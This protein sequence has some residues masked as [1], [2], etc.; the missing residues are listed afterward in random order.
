MTKVSCI[1][2]IRLYFVKVISFNLH[3]YYILSN[4]SHLAC[5]LIRYISYDRLVYALNWMYVDEINDSAYLLSD[6]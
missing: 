6:Y 4:L 1:L 5:V 3:G 2:K